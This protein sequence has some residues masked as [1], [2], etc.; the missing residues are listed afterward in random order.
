M[1]GALHPYEM[2]KWVEGKMFGQIDLINSLTNISWILLQFVSTP[3]PRPAGDS[4]PG[5]VAVSKSR[6]LFEEYLLLCTPVHL[7]RWGIQYPSS[8]ELFHPLKAPCLSAVFLKEPDP[9]TDCGA[10][11]DEPR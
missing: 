8:I 6:Q 2:V 11:G 3:F 10:S 7:N 4:Q 5:A 9:G 1:E